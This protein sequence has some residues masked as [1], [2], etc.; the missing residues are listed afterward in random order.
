[1][2]DF[3]PDVDPGDQAR[4]SDAS[5]NWEDSDYDS[6]DTESDSLTTDHS[7]GVE[8]ELESEEEALIILYLDSESIHPAINVLEYDDYRY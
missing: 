4:A 3:E 8:S 5:D 1:M 2:G 7:E 6:N